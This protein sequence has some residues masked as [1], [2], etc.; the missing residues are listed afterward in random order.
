MFDEIEASFTDKTDKERYILTNYRLTETSNQSSSNTTPAIATGTLQGDVNGQKFSVKFDSDI[1]YSWG[2]F[3]PSQANI[4]IE[5][6]NNSK[7][8]I[9][10]KNT[11]DGKALIS[12]FANGTSVTG[13]PKTI[14]WYEFD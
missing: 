14:N 4:N 1:K 3:A 10:I 2:E 6:T 7:N 8:T 11:T 9:T 13:Y 12:A 5:D